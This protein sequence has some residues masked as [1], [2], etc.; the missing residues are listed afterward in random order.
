MKKTWICI[1]FEKRIMINQ[2]TLTDAVY[3][4]TDNDA[5]MMPHLDNA[6]TKQNEIKKKEKDAV[7]TNNKK[8]QYI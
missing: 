8:K 7:E 4:I 6:N 2:V 3:P 5:Q 1:F